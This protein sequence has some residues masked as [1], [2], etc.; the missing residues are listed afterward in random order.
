MSRQA[1]WQ[2]RMIALNRCAVCGNTRDPKLSSVC[3][4]KCLE[5]QRKRYTPTTRG[6]YKLQ[7][8]KK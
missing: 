3:C 8:D 4:L 1:D 2:K 5:K 7:R 6:R